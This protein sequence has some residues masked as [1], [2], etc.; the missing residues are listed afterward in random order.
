[1][2]EYISRFDDY[3]NAIL[4]KDLRQTVR[5]KFFW[6]IYFLFLSLV[7]ILLF[8][9]MNESSRNGTGIGSYI[10]NTM[11]V[12]IYFVSSLI[13]P[14]QIGRK[15]GTEF[16][17]ANH[18]LLFIT[19]MKPSSI[20]WGKFLSGSV[21]ILMLYATLAP[22]LALT[23]FLGGVD[24]RTLFC[25]LLFTFLISNLAVMWQVFV[26]LTKVDS[27][28]GNNVVNSSGGIVF[29][30]IAW[31]AT[32]SLITESLYRFTIRA[33]FSEILTTLSVSILIFFLIMFGLFSACVSKLQPEAANNKY[34]LRVILSIIWLLGT[35]CSIFFNE[36]YLIGW[37]ICVLI[38]L[39][40]LLIVGVIGESETYSNRV[41]SEIPYSVFERFLKFP[42]FTGLAN[43]F[44]WIV[45][46]TLLT[47]VT[48]NL[49]GKIKFVSA[50]TDIPDITSRFCIF[51]I[52]IWT[53]CFLA[54]SIRK[55]FFNKKP[56]FNVILSVIILLIVSI[57]LYICN[58]FFNLYDHSF[59]SLSIKFLN[60]FNVFSYYSYRDLESQFFVTI[61][62]LG[63]ALLLNIRSL[64]KQFLSYFNRENESNEDRDF[65]QYMEQKK[66]ML[67][68]GKI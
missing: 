32:F 8:F 36:S 25:L 46:I 62:F 41:I 44:T 23:L 28:I 30:I 55:F 5:G 38:I 6:I 52:K 2:N 4:V 13:L 21:M 42:L 47:T 59:L 16:G 64:F 1:M 51:N 43:G 63:F 49:L 58:E 19:T 31:F 37:T 29:H 34:K 18:E 40:F 7:T 68:K 10:A 48:T 66:S 45:L 3:L 50:Y 9:T 65:Y 57:G 26:G 35:I 56:K 17:D 39:D 27:Y 12:I 54:N 53:Y 33:S 67:N 24:I 15:T 20:V 11:F 61:V 60:P 22:Y 14:I